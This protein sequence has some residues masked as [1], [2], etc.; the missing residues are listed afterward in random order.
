MFIEEAP[1][2]P[3]FL[4]F[5]AHTTAFIWFPGASMSMSALPLWVHSK[6]R[7]GDKRMIDTTKLTAC[8]L[9]ISKNEW[10]R[11]I[12]GTAKAYNNL[13]RNDKSERI[14]V[15]DRLLA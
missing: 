14:N 8:G 1:Q 6:G 11:F 4:A 3:Q 5:R 7:S 12:L 13:G 2:F 15:L 9:A 10:L